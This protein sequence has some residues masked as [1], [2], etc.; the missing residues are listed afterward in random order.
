MYNQNQMYPQQQNQQQMSYPQQA[1]IQ[2]PLQPMM[3]I[4]EQQALHQ[5]RLA[6]QQM[7]QM[8]QP[9]YQQQPQQ[10][11][12]QQ[13]QQMYQQQVQQPMLGGVQNT[14]AF[15]Q[16]VCS[17][18]PDAGRA[19]SARYNSS[20]YKKKYQAPVAEQL[21]EQQPQQTEQVLK[22]ALG[23]EYKLFI[24]PDNKV[25]EQKVG[26]EYM[27]IVTGNGGEVISNV[28][29]SF[30]KNEDGSMDKDIRTVACPVTG[31]FNKTMIAAELFMVKPHKHDP[32]EDPTIITPGMMTDIN[33]APTILL[34]RLANCSFCKITRNIKKDHFVDLFTGVE[35]VKDI[36]PKLIAVSKEVGLE[37]DKEYIKT[38]DRY[39]TGF[40]NDILFKTNGCP[41]KIESF[42]EDYPSLNEYLLKRVGESKTELYQTALNDAFAVLKRSIKEFLEVKDLAEAE[43]HRQIGLIYKPYGCGYINNEKLGLQLSKIPKGEIYCVTEKSYK[44]FYKIIEDL[45]IRIPANDIILMDEVGVYIIRKNILGNFTIERKK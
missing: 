10:V 5:Q 31:D 30:I 41:V 20:T 39:F 32:I 24:H 25:I 26:D 16:G 35:D 12:Q 42:I 45:H 27:Y 18:Q 2:Q 34:T 1:A 13:P 15:Q 44:G 17:P 43:M 29:Y 4:Q 40:V 19:T 21:Q 38:L 11:Y 9:V 33:L 36:H 6:Q 37:M 28:H 23:S 14:G 8:Q 3:S 7:Q 22:P